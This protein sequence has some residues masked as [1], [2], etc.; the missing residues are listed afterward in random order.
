MHI[1]FN[2]ILFKINS[3][4]INKFIINI[5]KNIYIKMIFIFI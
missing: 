3:I 5:E 1:S 2:I 4:K